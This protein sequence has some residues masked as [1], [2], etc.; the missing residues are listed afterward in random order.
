MS[1][2]VAR[3]QIWRSRCDRRP[4]SWTS[5]PWWAQAA[6]LERVLVPELP[7]HV[8]EREP[9]RSRAPLA[10]T[11]FAN[12]SHKTRHPAW[13][14]TTAT[15]SSAGRACRGPIRASRRTARSARRRPRRL[16]G[17][18]HP[19]AT[20][21]PRRGHLAPPARGRGRVRPRARAHR[22]SRATRSTTGARRSTSRWRTSAR[23]PVRA[24]GL[25]KG[26][27]HGLGAQRLPTRAHAPR[28]ALGAS[29]LTLPRAPFTAPTRP[30]GAGTFHWSPPMRAMFG[31]LT[32]RSVKQTPANLSAHPRR[33][34][35][36]LRHP[37]QRSSHDVNNP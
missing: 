26:G 8:I 10:A 21:A 16:V 27:R 35:S 13:S 18:V 22:P 24:G 28:P 19:G 31:Y 9:R 7:A 4:S 30:L 36:L 3:W 34:P 6:R 17:V 1:R 37:E 29:V 14:R 23:W 32:E 2:P 12:W 33:S 15:R 11:G 25:H 20:R 5:R